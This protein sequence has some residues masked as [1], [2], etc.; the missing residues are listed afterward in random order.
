M[1]ENV[2]KL[3]EK[4]SK[5]RILGR[6]LIKEVSLNDLKAVTGGSTSCSA[7]VADDCDQQAL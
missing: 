1:K 6:N 7:C 3:T 5:R 4:E 2:M